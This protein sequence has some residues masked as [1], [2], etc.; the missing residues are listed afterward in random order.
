MG[1]VIGGGI[2][3]EGGISIY[4]EVEIPENTVAPVVSGNAIARGTVTSTTGTWATIQVPT[5]TYQ[6]QQNASNITGATSNSYVVDVAYVGA[7]LQC[8]VKATNSYGNSSATSNSIGPVTANV[9]LAPTIGTATR[10]SATSVTVSF[11]APSSDGGSAITSYQVTSSP[12]GIT[13]TGGSSPITVTGLTTGTP[14]TFTVKAINSIGQSAASAASNSIAPAPNVGDVFRGGYFL[15][16]NGATYSVVSGG[17]KTGP[18]QGFT[19]INVYYG[20]NINGYTDWNAGTINNWDT[21]YINRALFTSLGIGFGTDT[22]W[23]G[24]QVFPFTS[25]KM[26]YKNMN[27]G[28]LGQAIMYAAEGGPLYYARPFRTAAWS[29]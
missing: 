10:A 15:S 3:I 24:I 1:I 27:N 13:A 25:K 9:P 18:Q 26:Y 21:A 23:T 29:A 8:V 7:N 20:V 6:W 11:T 28:A 4:K 17:N 16:D 12:G 22:Y 5:Y 2:S 19:A 14:Y